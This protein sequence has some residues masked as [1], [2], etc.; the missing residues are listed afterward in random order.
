MRPIFGRIPLFFLWVERG[1]VG[2]L[3]LTAEAAPPFTAAVMA[4]D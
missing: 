4:A 2:I 3:H 1:C